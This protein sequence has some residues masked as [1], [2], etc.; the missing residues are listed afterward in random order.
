M[1]HLADKQIRLMGNQSN[2]KKLAHL[3]LLMKKMINSGDLMT[4]QVPI[5]MKII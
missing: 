3:L 5:F 2:L 4:S 1:F